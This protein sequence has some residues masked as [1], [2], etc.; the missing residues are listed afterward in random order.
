V[1]PSRQ[2]KARHSNTESQLFT[3]SAN[4]QL[5]SL[6]RAEK[7]RHAISIEEL[8]RLAGLSFEETYEAVSE[9]LNA[10]LAN[11]YAVAN[12]LNLDPEVVLEL[13]NSAHE[14]RDAHDSQN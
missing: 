7:Q 9:P 13:L 10:P 1:S 12:A 5:T 3:E 14:T 8:G 4:Q 2:T 11:L 6:I